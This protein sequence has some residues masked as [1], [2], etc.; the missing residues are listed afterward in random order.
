[1]YYKK[2]MSNKVYKNVCKLFCYLRNMRKLLL[3]YNIINSGKIVRMI[4]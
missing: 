1:M 3:I 4:K 2:V